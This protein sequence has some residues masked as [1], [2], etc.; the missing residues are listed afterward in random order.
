MTSRED[1]LELFDSLEPVDI[2]F[3]IGRWKGEGY[4]TGHPHDGLLEAYN[5]YGKHFES[6]EDV[7]PL[8]FTNRRGDI[9]RINPGAMAAGGKQGGTPSRIAIKIFQLLMPLL[10]TSESRAR[11]RMTEYRGKLS[12]TMIYDQLPVN[13]VFRK[14][15]DNT[16]FS[17][18]DNRD[19]KDP[20]FFK[21]KRDNS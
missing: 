13:D 21:L 11:L 17:V 3:M 19:V 7:H 6:S 16:V 15:D 14:L 4:P 9:V 8:L 5:W 10:S 1:A 2:D 12:A 20:F 18:M